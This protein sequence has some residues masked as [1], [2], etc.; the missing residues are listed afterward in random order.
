MA[1]MLAYLFAQI[2]REVAVNSIAV[3]LFKVGSLLGALGTLALL[4]LTVLVV[5]SGIPESVFQ[6]LHATDRGLLTMLRDFGPNLYFWMVLSGIG[7]VTAVVGT[8]GSRPG[9]SARG[10]LIISLAGTFLW[11]HSMVPALAQ[12]RT[13]KGFAATIDTTVPA[14]AVVEYLGPDTPCDLRFYLVHQLIHGRL[15]SSTSRFIVIGESDF[16][17]LDP[18]RRASLQLLTNSGAGLNSSRLMLMKARD[19]R[20]L[21]NDRKNAAP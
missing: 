21:N 8:L 18:S 11:F 15:S 10:L 7:A 16:R 14:G 3:M 17:R 1:V 5:S 2:D 13:L 20:P 4:A 19:A 12:R 6:Q 9:R